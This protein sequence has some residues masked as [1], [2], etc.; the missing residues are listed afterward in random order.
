MKRFNAREA[1]NISSRQPG[2]SRRPAAGSASKLRAVAT[3]ASCSERSEE[4]GVKTKG[5]LTGSLEILVH[6]QPTTAADPVG[7]PKMEGASGQEWLELLDL[8][9]QSFRS[10]HL[11][12][13]QRRMYL[14]GQQC[15]GILQVDRARRWRGLAD[16]SGVFLLSVSVCTVNEQAY[17]SCSVSCLSQTI[18][19][20]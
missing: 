12:A 6:R 19:R 20:T 15:K 11:R 10:A 14:A 8:L 4:F 17:G 1:C 18:L 5:L 9:V 2:G 16:R 7:S 13:V 3:L